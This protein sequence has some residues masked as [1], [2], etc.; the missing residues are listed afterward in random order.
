LLIERKTGAAEPHLFAFCESDL[1]LQVAGL[2][3][4]AAAICEAPVEAPRAP[5]ETVGANMTRNAAPVEMRAVPMTVTDFLSHRVCRYGRLISA[6]CRQRGRGCHLGGECRADS[7]GRGD[8]KGFEFHVVLHR[9]F[10]LRHVIA[11][12]ANGHGESGALS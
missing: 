2:P 1:L 4:R 10:G 6:G 8:G 5:A 11:F 3:A 9:E 12:Y 7:E